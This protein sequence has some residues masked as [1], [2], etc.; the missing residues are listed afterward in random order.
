MSLS[1]IVS[2]LQLALAL[3]AAAQG[4]N[5]P[6]SLRDQATLVANQ[7]ISQAT[8][9]LFLSLHMRNHQLRLAR[10]ANLKRE[11]V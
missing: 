6:Q 2:L 8:A 4:H 3:L 5:V 10:R 1:A 7:A 11:H 9:A